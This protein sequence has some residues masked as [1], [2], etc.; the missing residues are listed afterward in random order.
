LEHFSLDYLPL[1]Q[2]KEWLK[3]IVVWIADIHDRLFD[4][5]KTFPSPLTDKDLH[6]LV[7]GAF[8]LAVFIFS[9]FLFRLLS[10]LNRYGMM[11]WLFS[12]AVVL[13]VAFAIEVGQHLTNTGNL[14]LGDIA[15][16]VMGFLY[17]SAGATALYLIF[18]LLRRLFRTK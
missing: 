3:E 2:Y 14:E 1:Q 8:G 15:Y 11:A 5:S 17:A 16:G 18:C 7:I 9:F 12:L 6:F 13:F 10:R 4:Y